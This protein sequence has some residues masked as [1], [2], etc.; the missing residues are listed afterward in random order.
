MGLASIRESLP[1]FGGDTGEVE[2]AGNGR[3]V[4][5]SKVRGGQSGP[6]GALKV[7]HNQFLLQQHHHCGRI[8][9]V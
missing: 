5:R 7:D 4:K 9:K 3:G 2:G 6:P 1:E 8:V